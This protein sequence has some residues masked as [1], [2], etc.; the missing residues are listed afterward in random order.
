MDLGWEGAS[1]SR[2]DLV[3]TLPV[4]PEMDHLAT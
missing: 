2:S 4:K 3:L 1:P